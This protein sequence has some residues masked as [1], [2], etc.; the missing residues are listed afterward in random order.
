MIQRLKNCI[1][2][3]KTDPQIKFMRWYCKLGHIYMI[4][5]PKIANW[6]RRRIDR[7]KKE[8]YQS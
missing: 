8:Y 3:F 4:L 5:F 2:L 7:L 1:I 6:E